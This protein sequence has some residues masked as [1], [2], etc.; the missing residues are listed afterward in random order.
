LGIEHQSADFVRYYYGISQD[1][2][3]ASDYTAYHPGSAV[4][5]R[6]SLMVEYPV[7]PHW[8]VNAQIARKWLGTAISDSPVVR[9]K[10]LDSAIIALSYRF[11]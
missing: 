4:N 1:E 7:M 3:A 6:V 8:N 5:S 9:D 10:H 2:A 11:K